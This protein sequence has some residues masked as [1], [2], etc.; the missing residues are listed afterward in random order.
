M[1]R[2]F[3]S[4]ICNFK[5]LSLGIRILY[6]I[7][8]LTAVAGVLVV[9]Y[10][11]A[12][13]FGVLIK[14]DKI[15]RGTEVTSIIYYNNSV[16]PA[17]T[18]NTDRNI[19]NTD[20]DIDN[21]EITANQ[22]V[23][24][25]QEGMCYIEIPDLKIKAPILDGVT[26]DVLDIAVGHFPESS[27]IGSGNYCLAGHSSEV[28]DCVF[29]NLRLIEKGTRIQIVNEEG[30]CYTYYVT[31]IMTVDPD[32]IWVLGDFNDRRVTLVTCTDSGNRRQVVT[33][34]LMSEQEYRDYAHNQEL[35]KLNEIKSLKFKMCDI[36]VSKYFEKELNK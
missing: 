11:I 31:D 18:R 20:N 13:E 23:A 21:I 22:K 33:G 6:C 14:S 28:Y 3:K 2:S 32:D 12:V 4:V 7:G 35:R 25:I 15:R 27:N 26:K 30:V 17:E 9:F 8:L 1:G 16:T 5:K 36:E 19:L 29:N 24:P 34:L 10:Y